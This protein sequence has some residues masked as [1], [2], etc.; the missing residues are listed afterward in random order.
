MKVIITFTCTFCCDKLR[1]SIVY[2]SGKK[3]GK[4]GE[5][6]SPTAYGLIMRFVVMSNN[7]SIISDVVFDS[8]SL[9]VLA[10]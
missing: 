3:C 5:F 4:L 9:R 1:K 8:T 10:L 6:F 7:I 2:G